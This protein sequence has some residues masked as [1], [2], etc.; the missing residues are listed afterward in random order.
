[1]IA[2]SLDN[3]ALVPEVK[4]SIDVTIVAVNDAPENILPTAPLVAEEDVPYRI[5]GLQVK[6]VDAGNST[7]EVRLSVGH[8]TLTLADGSG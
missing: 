7:I 2:Q 3:G 1:M 5:D 4:G 8:G 6:D